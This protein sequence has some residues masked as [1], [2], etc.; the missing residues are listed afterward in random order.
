[1]NHRT[2]KRVKDPKSC[3]DCKFC[4]KEAHSGRADTYA[5]T[6]MPIRAQKKME[7]GFYINREQDVRDRETSKSGMARVGWDLACAAQLLDDVIQYG[8]KL[9]VESN[10]AILAKARQM[11]SHAARECADVIDGESDK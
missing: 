9:T 7:C 5:C 4:R 10:M 11:L 6:M 1:M 8:E 2:V 3:I